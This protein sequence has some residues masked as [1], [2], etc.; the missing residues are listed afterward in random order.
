MTPAPLT[1]SLFSFRGGKDRIEVLA[2]IE[3]IGDPIASQKPVKPKKMLIL[4]LSCVLGGF[5]GLVLAYVREAYISRKGQ[6][7]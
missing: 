5:V 1:A 4:A 6:S 2:P 3:K 7:G